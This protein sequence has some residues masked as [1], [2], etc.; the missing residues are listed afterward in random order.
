MS[1]SQRQ[2]NAAGRAFGKG[3]R[4]TIPEDL[5]IPDRAKLQCS[6]RREFMLEP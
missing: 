4:A 6:A 3:P 1:A 5:A 2:D